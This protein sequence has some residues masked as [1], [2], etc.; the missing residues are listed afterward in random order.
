MRWVEKHKMP[1]S[2][3]RKDHF[4]NKAKSQGFRSRAYFKLEELSAKYKLF[5]TGFKVL[6][7][8]AWPGGWLQFAGKA[9]GP[10]GLVLGLDLV[11]IEA[12]AESHIKTLRGDA[13]DPHVQQQAVA[14]AG[15]KFD[16]VLSDMSPK[17]SGVREADSAAAVA[18]AEAALSACRFCLKEDGALVIKLFKGVGTEEFVRGARSSFKKLAREELE[19][20]RKTSNEYYLVGR[21]FRISNV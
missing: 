14:L 15:A 16:V 2:Y 8:G 17:L 7:L 13:C 1:G 3:N 4:Y 10:K 20:S 11:E 19:A 18:L 5:R 6:D 12:F 21:G 9:V